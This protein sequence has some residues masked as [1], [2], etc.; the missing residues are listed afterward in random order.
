LSAPRASGQPAAR[1]GRAIPTATKR[2]P[3]CAETIQ[4][5]A[6]KCRH[7][8][9]SLIVP[10]RLHMSSPWVAGISVMFGVLGAVAEVTNLFWNQSPSPSSDDHPFSGVG[11]TGTGD[12][13]S[14]LVI[15]SAILLGVAGLAG[16]LLLRRRPWL[17]AGIL[18]AAGAAGLIVTLVAGTTL[19]V[20]ALS[21]LL[22]VA[23]VVS[24]VVV[25]RR[26]KAA[27]VLETGP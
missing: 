2:C 24:F 25:H 27:L 15:V 13:A 5:E 9:S 7:C 18:V 19:L 10:R 14:A 22:L 23:G 4:A 16:G 17:G 3:F 6:L 26:S 8:R 12:D 21:A 1:P 20:V 11:P